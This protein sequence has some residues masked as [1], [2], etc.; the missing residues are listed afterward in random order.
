MTE[1]E[2]VETYRRF[3]DD[4]TLSMTRDGDKVIFVSDGRFGLHADGEWEK[5][6]SVGVGDIFRRMPDRHEQCTF[7][8]L[9]ILDI[10]VKIRYE[11]S[12]DH[13]SFGK[14]MVSVDSGII[15]LK[16]RDK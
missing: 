11:S 15:V 10:G 2:N 1:G 14:D 3:F 6:F 5:S 13:R 7:R 4:H 12:F 8:V 16:Y 9:E